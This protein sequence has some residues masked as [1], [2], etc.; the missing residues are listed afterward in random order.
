MF[1][2]LFQKYLHQFTNHYQLVL[3]IKSNSGELAVRS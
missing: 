2:L 1:P 3:Y